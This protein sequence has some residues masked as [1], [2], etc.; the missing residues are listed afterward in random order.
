MGHRDRARRGEGRP[1]RAR[2]QRRAR[3]GLRGH[4]A[5]QGAHFTGRERGGHAPHV[6]GPAHVP[7]PHG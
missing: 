3:R 5:P 7:A 6:A 2:G 4:P 1:A